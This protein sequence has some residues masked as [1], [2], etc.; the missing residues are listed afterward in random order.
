MINRLE[1]F[2]VLSVDLVTYDDGLALLHVRVVDEAT[3]C[4]DGPH[5]LNVQV[6]LDIQ[7]LVLE[8]DSLTRERADGV[9][10]VH[11]YKTRLVLEGHTKPLKGMTL[12]KMWWEE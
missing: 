5:V 10:E 6:R 11:D 4:T 12:R 9:T 8:F 1:S 2:S 3:N 7:H